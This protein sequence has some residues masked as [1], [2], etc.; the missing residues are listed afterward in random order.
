MCSSLSRNDMC[1]IKSL[2]YRQ[3]GLTAT[4]ATPSMRNDLTSI[5]FRNRIM[6]SLYAVERLEMAH[7]LKGHGGCVNCINFNETGDLLVSGGDDLH[8]CIWKWASNKMVLKCNTGHRQNIFQTKFIENGINANGFNIVSSSRDGDVRYIEIGPD[9]TAS[10]SRV[11]Y[12]HSRRPVNKIAISPMSPFEFLSA[13]EDGCVKRFDLRTKECD[14][15]L[16]LRSHSRKVP[17]Y[18]IATHPFDTEFCVCGMD[19]YVRVH[20]KRNVKDSMKL[21]FPST[22]AGVSIC[23]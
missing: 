11:L 20:D 9:G 22:M 8:L 23:R 7:N 14:E 3:H 2:L 17:L 1:L 4:T 19:K 10:S 16:S 15:V 6:G 13:G 5:P 21:L 12:S 18:S